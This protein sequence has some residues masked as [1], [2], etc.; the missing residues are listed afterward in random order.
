VPALARALDDLLRDPAV[1]EE[2]LRHAPEHLAPHTSAAVAQ[3]Y[4]DV[5]AAAVRRVP[6]EAAA[7]VRSGAR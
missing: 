6:R 2:H 7:P 5:L 3:R 4:L 1:R